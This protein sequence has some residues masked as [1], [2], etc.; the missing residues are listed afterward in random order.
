MGKYQVY[1]HKSSCKT[2]WLGGYIT[3]CTQYIVTDAVNLLAKLKIE[4][5]KWPLY[6]CDVRFFSYCSGYV[7]NK[8]T[9]VPCVRIIYNMVWPLQLLCAIIKYVT[10]AS[11]LKAIG[12]CS[13]YPTPCNASTVLVHYI[14][15][16][17]G[18]CHTSTAIT[19][20]SPTWRRWEG[21]AVSQ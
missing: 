7:L 6:V 11:V 4:I 9:S 5:F 17:A 20:V 8:H 1:Q 13:P 3:Y 14:T 19:V 15:Q 21:G 10:T 18:C 16:K 2:R 12:N